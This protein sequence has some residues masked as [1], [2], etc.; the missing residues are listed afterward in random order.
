M[1]RVI[2]SSDDISTEVYTIDWYW[3]PNG[4]EGESM[5]CDSESIEGDFKTALNC[6]R[7]KSNSDEFGGIHWAGGSIIDING[8]C[9]YEITSDYDEWDNT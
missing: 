3:Y 4:V 8:N 1:K 5:E 2:K 9:V 6:L 7:E